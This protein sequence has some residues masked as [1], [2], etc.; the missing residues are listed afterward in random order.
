MKKNT[1]G[2]IIVLP[3]L[4][5]GIV[6]IVN[7]IQKT[8]G[9]KP[10]DAVDEIEVTATQIN[11]A[12]FIV[13]NE[14]LQSDIVQ[15][16]GIVQAERQESE[17]APTFDEALEMEVVVVGSPQSELRRRVSSRVSMRSDELPDYENYESHPV[18]SG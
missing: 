17:A 3:F 12:E 8:N 18:F 5:A 10:S 16:T 15:N 9:E 14:A 13:G 7:T 6:A 2:L 11:H 4:V 1:K